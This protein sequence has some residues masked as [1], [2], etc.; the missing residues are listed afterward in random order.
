MARTEII[1]LTGMATVGL[2]A[3]L[4]Q[5]LVAHAAALATTAQRGRAVGM[6]TSGVVT[7]ILAARSVAGVVADLGGW[8]AVYLTSALA[9][10]VMIGVLMWV[11]PRQPAKRGPEAYIDALV[12]IPRTV[13]GEPCLLL[14]GTLAL[15][16]FASFSSSFHSAHHH[17]PIPIPG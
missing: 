12:S 1:L 2:L 6:V 8:R 17:F 10:A 15:L 7:G 3:V 5:I 13:L 16:I 4:V 11:L 9:M 14:R